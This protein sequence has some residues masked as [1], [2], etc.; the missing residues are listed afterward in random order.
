MASNKYAQVAVTGRGSEVPFH[1]VLLQLQT[2]IHKCE[3]LMDYMNERV[4]HSDGFDDRLAIIAA[5]FNI[6][7]DGW[8]EPVKIAEVLIAELRKANSVIITLH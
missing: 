5:Y 1:E 2:E 6:E 8:Y 3:P 4:G 7:M